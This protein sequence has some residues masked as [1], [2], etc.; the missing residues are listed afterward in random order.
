M[1][2]LPLLAICALF[3]A[4]CS[5]D[6]NTGKTFCDTACLNDTI[7]FNGGEPF[8]QTL[9]IGVKNCNADSVVW[10]HGETINRRQIR[11]FEFLGQEIKIN[12]KAVNA[13]FQDTSMIWLSFNDC[14]NGRGY[15][16]KLPYTK[17]GIQ[18]ITGALNS[19]D[20][21][22]SLDP[23]LRAY[24]D[25]GNIYVVN[26]KDGKQA[27]MTFK[28]EYDIDFNDIHKGIDSINITKKS[29]YVKLLSNGKPDEFRK[30]ISL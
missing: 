30:E 27:E 15:L 21:K 22:F 1:K 12:P 19:F 13:A 3:F 29:I 6:G 7:R 24:T 17:G 28:K 9:T 11:L 10:T 4:S 5:N 25:R 16:L 20:P 14:I 8:N 26:V 23:D 18:K 2:L